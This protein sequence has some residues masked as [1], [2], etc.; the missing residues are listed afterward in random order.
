VGSVAREQHA[1]RP[2][3]SG[4]PGVTAKPTWALDPHEPHP[5]SVTLEDFAGLGYEIARPGRRPQIDTPPAAGQRGEDHRRLVEMHGNEVVVLVPALHRRVKHGPVRIDIDARELDPDGIADG[6]VYPVA[7]DDPL[8]DNLA[9]FA[10]TLQGRCHRLLSR[11][12]AD[13]AG[14]AGNGTSMGLEIVG[15]H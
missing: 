2:I 7:P 13:Q 6:T 9:A 14:R 10:V 11:L 15:E 8:R 12:Q 4:N 1:A 5:R 3:A